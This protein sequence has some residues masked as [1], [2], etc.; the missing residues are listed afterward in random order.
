[1]SIIFARSGSWQTKIGF[2][3]PEQKQDIFENITSNIAKYA[4][5]SS[6]IR[7]TT[8]DSDQFCGFSVL[9]TCSPADVHPESNGIGIESIRTMMR[10]MNG[11]CTVE[12]T[13]NAF[14]TALLFPKF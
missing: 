5:P 13:E 12:R 4:E 3:Q 2:P 10:Q 7:I 14:E 1:M 8:L 6:E 11:V 9:N